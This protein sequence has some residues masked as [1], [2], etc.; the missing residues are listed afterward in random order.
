MKNNNTAISEN[1]VVARF[2]LLWRHDGQ[3]HRTAALTSL[4]LP[5]AARTIRAQ[6]KFLAN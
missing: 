4:W 6:R 3:P 5:P 1:A 2:T